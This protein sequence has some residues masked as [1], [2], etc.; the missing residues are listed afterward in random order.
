VGT[1]GD[2]AVNG[3]LYSPPGESWF[4]TTH[5]ALPRRA[6]VRVARDRAAGVA[7]VREACILEAVRHPGLPRV[8]EI[9]VED[10]LPWIADE[11]VEGEPLAGP[12]SVAQVPAILRD[13]C[14]IL[15][16]CHRRGVIHDGIWIDAVV[17]APDRG[18]PLCLL[19][20]RRA[21]L[22]DPEDGR[23]DVYAL[24]MAVYAALPD[25]APLGL[26]NLIGEMLD[27]RPTAEE[28]GRE[29]SRLGEAAGSFED[30]DI[31]EVIL[32]TD[33]SREPAPVT[34]P[35]KPKWTPAPA[36]SM[37]PLGKPIALLKRPDRDY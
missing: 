26:M 4:E 5:R 27:E 11:L 21:R 36:M 22:G 23:D 17:R 15:A 3:E 32:L 6:R 10:G 24:G 19:N 1:L 8:F 14:A 16:Q 13:A 12:L 29:A 30:P 37:T 2:Y 9:G 25:S 33:L 28:V 31:E 34:I 18:F 35:T 7:L 20:W